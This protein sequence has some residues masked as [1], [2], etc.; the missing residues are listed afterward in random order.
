[1]NNELTNF[2]RAIALRDKMISPTEFSYLE[3]MFEPNYLKVYE[4]VKNSL[5]YENDIPDENLALNNNEFRFI[6]MSYKG[7]P[8]NDIN[9]L[10]LH[11]KS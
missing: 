11:Q 5:Q 4:Y 7:H 8:S 9:W 2:D 3:R 10:L 1:M 6:K